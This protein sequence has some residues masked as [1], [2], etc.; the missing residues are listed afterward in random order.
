[1]HPACLWILLARPVVALSW[2]TFSGW[3]RQGASVWCSYPEI[4]T[5]VLP[6]SRSCLACGSTSLISWISD[7]GSSLT[8]GAHAQRGLYYL[9]CHSIRPSACLSVT[10][11]SPATRNK[12]TKK[13]YQLVQCHT[14]FIFKNSDFGKSAAFQSYN[15]KQSEGAN[16]QISTGLPR[17]ALR[18]M[19]APEV[20]TQGE[21]RLPRAI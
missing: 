14:G 17:P 10:T 3:L 11:F 12:T 21:Y 20:A 8:L 6:S 2:A 4:V 16:M 9:V 1:M 5:G 18:T 19:E 7:P 15:V 13:W